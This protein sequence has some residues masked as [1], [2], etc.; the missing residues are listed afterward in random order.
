[1]N[2]ESRKRSLDLGVIGNCEIA[3]LV[4]ESASIVWCCLP[5]MDADPDGAKA[6]GMEGKGTRWPRLA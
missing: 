6:P 1:M 3:A 5:R 2:A 4:D